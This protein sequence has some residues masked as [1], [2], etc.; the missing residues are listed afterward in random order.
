MLKMIYLKIATVVLVLTLVSS[1]TSKKKMIYFATEPTQAE[2]NT[3][4]NNPVFHKDDFC[5]PD[6]KQR[7]IFH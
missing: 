7:I 4:F 1:C 3:K 5:T 2:A 6:P